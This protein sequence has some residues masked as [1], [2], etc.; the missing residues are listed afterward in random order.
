M[1]ADPLHGRTVVVT[2]AARGVGAVLARDLSRRGARLALPGHEKKALT[3]V[4][5]GLSAVI[6]EQLNTR[7]SVERARQE[8]VEVLEHLTAGESAPGRSLLDKS[9]TQRAE[10]GPDW[11]ERSTGEWTTRRGTGEQSTGK[12]GTGQSRGPWPGCGARSPTAGGRSRR[13]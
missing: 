2:G 4:A 10:V 6:T 12:R 9:G 7:R 5:A 13:R 8:L 11:D 3:A 1:K